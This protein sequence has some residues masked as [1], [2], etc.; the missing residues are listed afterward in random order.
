MKAVAARWCITP[1]WMSKLVANEDRPSHYNDALFGLP[2]MCNAERQG[3]R[4]AVRVG[5]LV[6]NRQRYSVG[7]ILSA[8]EA[9][10]SMA[11]PGERAWVST[12]S[13]REG[14]FWYKIS[15]ENG[16]EDWFNETF[17]DDYFAQTGLSKEL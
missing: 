2:S 10:G 16:Q 5:R 17:L 8:M 3:K 4:R 6:A 9:I 11:E 1:V 12:A 7:E 15:F 13:I 14:K